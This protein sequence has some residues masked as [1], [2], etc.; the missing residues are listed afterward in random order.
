MPITVQQ[1][2][3][4][5]IGDTDAFDRTLPIDLGSLFLHRFGPIPAVRDV[6]GQ[7]GP[8]E[9][10]GQVRTVVLADGTSMSEELV[11]VDSPTVFA[12][13]LTELG[14]PFGL[15]VDHVDG[16]WQF[17]GVGDHTAVTWQWSLYPRSAMTAPLV[18]VIGYFWKGYARRGLDQL[19]RLIA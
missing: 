2:R 3:L 5:P 12:Y 4:V 18:R 11:Q 15:L 17:D 19:A 6:R 1:K 14:G 10:V 7:D 8:W 13:R 16:R 9:R